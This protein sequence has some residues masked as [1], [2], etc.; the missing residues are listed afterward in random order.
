MC[1]AKEDA[2]RLGLIAAETE[3]PQPE[4]VDIAT[5]HPYFVVASIEI[6]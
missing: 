4:N 2:V 5:I 3:E 1:Q 6:N